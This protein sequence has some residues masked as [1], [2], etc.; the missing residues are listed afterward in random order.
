MEDSLESKRNNFDLSKLITRGFNPEWI[1]SSSGNIIKIKPE[2]QVLCNKEV[3]RSQHFKPI[4][5][6]EKWAL[7]LPLDEHEKCRVEQIEFSDGK[8]YFID[9]NNRVSP[10]IHVI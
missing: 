7:C 2:F 10:K 9:S 5:K 3:S 8:I 1:E 4:A 6:V